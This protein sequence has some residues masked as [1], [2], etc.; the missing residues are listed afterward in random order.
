MSEELTLQQQE[1]E[2]Q[3]EGDELLNQEP[4]QDSPEGAMDGEAADYGGM[5]RLFI[6]FF[7]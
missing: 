5:S 3:M 7:M 6:K 4:L 2:P 1:G